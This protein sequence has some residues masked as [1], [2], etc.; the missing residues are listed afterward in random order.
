MSN[1]CGIKKLFEQTKTIMQNTPSI[2]QEC[3]RISS[4][5]L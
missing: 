3:S 1:Y 2:T 5:G 4:E